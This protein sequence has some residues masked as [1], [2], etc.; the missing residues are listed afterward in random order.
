MTATRARAWSLSLST[1][2]V[3]VLFSVKFRKSSEKSTE[4]H[5]FK[6]H[7]KCQISRNFG[8]CVKVKRKQNYCET[9]QKLFSKM[10]YGYN[11]IMVSHA[12]NQR[13]MSYSRQQFNNGMT[14]Q[15]PSLQDQSFTVA[16]EDPNCFG[17]IKVSANSATP[18]S[19]AT[20]VGIQRSLY[21]FSS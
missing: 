11:N 8:E 18:Y 15:S 14:I 7:H 3:S 19:D 21:C 5:F 16:S 4:S 20:K 6:F 13:N 12:N 2:K 9:L 17:S 10:V 1:P